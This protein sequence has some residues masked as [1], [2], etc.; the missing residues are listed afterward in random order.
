MS[1]VAS[2]HALAVIKAALNAVPVVGGSIASLIGD[3]I[4]TATQR[5]VDQALSDLSE[6]LTQ[7]GDRIDA[8][9]IDRDQFSE[10]FKSTYLVMVR[11]H[12]KHKLLG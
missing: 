8:T 11:T 7:L 1:K 5:A 3:Y 4:Q 10:L 12:N 6:Q 2:E 9:K